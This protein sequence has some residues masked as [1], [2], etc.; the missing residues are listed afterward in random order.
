MVLWYV[1]GL[2]GS[3]SVSLTNKLC[4][5]FGLD[6]NAKYRALRSLRGAKLVAVKCKRGRSPLVTILGCRGEP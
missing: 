4:L 2:S 3:L 6:R 1:A 5:Q